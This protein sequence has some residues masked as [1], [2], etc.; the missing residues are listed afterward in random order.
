MKEN[1][2][3]LNVEFT[4]CYFDCNNFKQKDI[5]TLLYVISQSRLI[6]DMN[7]A[8]YG[9]I[10]FDEENDKPHRYPNIRF[11]NDDGSKIQFNRKGTNCLMFD[12]YKTDNNPTYDKLFLYHTN[13]KNGQGIWYGWIIYDSVTKKYS[14]R[15]FIEHD[16]QELLLALNRCFYNINTVNKLNQLLDKQLTRKV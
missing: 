6:H 14:H 3:T 1:K 12:L 8:G 10:S 9:V 11:A 7:F 15:F 2:N 13:A 5:D 16:I 4:H